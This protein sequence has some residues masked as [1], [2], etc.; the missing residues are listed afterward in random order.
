MHFKNYGL[1]RI[2]LEVLFENKRAQYVYE[3]CGFVK[4]G[5]KHQSVFKNGKFCDMLIY[6]LLNENI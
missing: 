5:V 4:E 6:S 2:E 3:K 1:H